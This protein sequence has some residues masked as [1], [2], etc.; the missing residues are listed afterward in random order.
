MLVDTQSI[1]WSEDSTPLFESII[2]HLSSTYPDHG[3]IAKITMILFALHDHV[4]QTE[5][6]EPTSFSLL[7]STKEGMSAF[8]SG[9]LTLL[10]TGTATVRLAVFLFLEYCLSDATRSERLLFVE[11]G[12][13]RRL[14]STFREHGISF[15]G[16]F[17]PSLVSIVSHCLQPANPRYF[18][19]YS[20][21][22]TFLIPNIHETT[23]DEVIEPMEGFFEIVFRHRFDFREDELSSESLSELLRT[24]LGLS[25]FHAQTMELVLSLPIALTFASCVSFYS[26]DT[27]F[28]GTFFRDFAFGRYLHEDGDDIPLRERSDEVFR[29]LKEEGLDDLLEYHIKA[30]D[31]PPW[32]QWQPIRVVRPIL[33]DIG[34]NVP[35]W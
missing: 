29:Q 3:D 6:T 31:D 8:S 1:D 16:D 5:E 7:A 12:F 20:N 15:D 14:S 32:N 28:I 9:I 23:F 19:R 35:P 26:D 33:I 24:M 34:G 27:L 10:S 22:K 18:R 25:P 21:E 30:Y 13:F 17:G 2:T 4:T 11:A